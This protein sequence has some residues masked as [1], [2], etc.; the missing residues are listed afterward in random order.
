MMDEKHQAIFDN[1]D[2]NPFKEAFG[3]YIN[4]RL[5]RGEALGKA[6][7]RLI[8]KLNNL[9][10]PFCTDIITREM[11]DHVFRCCA[12]DAGRVSQDLFSKVKGFADFIAITK[13]E[14]FTFNSGYWAVRKANRRTFVF[15]DDELK[16]II[17]AVDSY[18][19]ESLR[20]KAIYG[21]ACP[22]PVLTRI[23]MGT[24]MRIGEILALKVDDIDLKTEVITVHDGKNHVSRWVPIDHSLALVLAWYIEA[25][26]CT[27]WLFP[28]EKHTGAAIVVSG[29]EYFYAEHAFKEA[30]I[31]MHGGEKPVIHSFRHTFITK[32]L[33]RLIKGGMDEHAAIPLV[34]AYV[35]HTNINDTYHYL[36][37]TQEA[38]TDFNSRQGELEALIPEVEGESYE[39]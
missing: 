26:K 13:A 29:V 15:T 31:G 4:M 35:G 9:L 25:R 16:R 18:G 3:R 30:G 23:L 10:A 14:S 32:A 17:D 24:G 7:M 2:D 39:W 5:A 21:K 27:D 19:R 12:D 28:S 8:Q 33:D 6:S 11:V 37:L 22:Y 38:T 20:A 1:F 34:A 36:H